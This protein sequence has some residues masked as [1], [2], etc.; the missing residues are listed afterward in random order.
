MQ[1]FSMIQGN[2]CREG[3]TCPN[4]HLFTSWQEQ[5]NRCFAPLLLDESPEDVGLP[6]AAATQ[7]GWMC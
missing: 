3:K 6:G 7:G 2:G 1:V 5:K 4:R